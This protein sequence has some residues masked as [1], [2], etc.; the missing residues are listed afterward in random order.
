MKQA[1]RAPPL[2]VLLRLGFGGDV[3]MRRCQLPAH[4]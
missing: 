1:Y 3:A 4:C 2:A